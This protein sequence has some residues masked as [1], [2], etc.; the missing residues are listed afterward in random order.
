M[1]GTLTYRDY[2]TADRV[3]TLPTR[4]FV[5]LTA[6]NQLV[7][8][9]IFD[10]GPVKTVYSYETM[11][12]DRSAQ[13][14][15]WTSGAEKKEVFNHRIISDAEESGIR[16]LVFERKKDSKFLRFS[17]LFSGTTVSLREDEVAADGSTTN[18]NEYRFQRP[19]T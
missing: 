7:L 2:S 8:D 18:R 3:V 15:V 11:L 19:G 4:L 14:V 5:A 17:M 16:K 12:F 9:Y 10:D 6:P 13:Q 1:A